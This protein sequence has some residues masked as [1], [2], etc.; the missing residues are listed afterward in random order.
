MTEMTKKTRNKL[1]DDALKNFPTD[2]LASATAR[3][4]IKMAE[5]FLK[6]I[7]HEGPMAGKLVLTS[8]VMSIDEKHQ[9]DHNSQIIYSMAKIGFGIMVGELQTMRA[10]ETVTEIA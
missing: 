2:A 9:E 7:D 4:R 1:I 3:G 5:D 6:F 8:L 10:K